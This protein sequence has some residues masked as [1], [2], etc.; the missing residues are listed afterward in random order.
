MLSSLSFFL[1]LRHLP[2]VYM[3]AL[4]ILWWMFK[5]VL[6]SPF[7]IVVPKTFFCWSLWMRPLEADR[8]SFMSLWNSFWHSVWLYHHIHKKELFQFKMSCFSLDSDH[9]YPLH[10][11]MCRHL[12]HIYPVS[13]FCYRL[14]L[15]KAGVRSPL[16]S[17]STLN[18]IMLKTI[19]SNTCT[20]CLKDTVG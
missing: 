11:K 7:V 8:T 13:S 5:G 15:R 18:F 10:I 9:I 1:L 17:E 2:Q 20:R 19:T 16:R 4:E 14:W 3:C 6:F 12:R